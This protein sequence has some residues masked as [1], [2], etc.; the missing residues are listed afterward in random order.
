METQPAND[1]PRYVSALKLLESLFGYK[2]FRPFQYAIIDSLCDNNDVLAVMPTGGGKSI[3]YQLPALMRDGVGIVVSPLIAL[4]DD[5]VNALKLLGIRAECIHSAIDYSEINRIERALRNRQLDILYVAPERA[6]TARMLDLL[7]DTQISLFAIDEAH[8]VSQWGHDF[9]PD[10]QQLSKLKQLFPEVPTVA[11]TATADEKT[12]EEIIRQLGLIRARSYIASFDRPNIHYSVYTGANSKQALLNFIKTHYDTNTAGIVYCQTRKKV[13]STCD[14]LIQNG[15]DALPY[16]A[17]MADS[18]RQQNQKTFKDRDGLIMV[19]TIAF[20][21][22]I[23][24]PNVRFVAH[25]NIPKCLESYYQETGRAGRDGAPAYAWM[26]FNLED[27][28]TLRRLMYEADVNPIRKQINHNKLEYMLGFCEIIDCRRQ[29][30]LSYF[31]E[32]LTQPCGNCDNCHAP[33]QTRDESESARIAIS[34][35]YRSGQRF[36]VNHV[37]D[38]LLGKTTDKVRQYRHEKLSTFGLGK[39]L[40]APEWRNI[41]RQLLAHGYIISNPD[42]YGALQLA[43]K[44]R[45]LLRNE[46]SFHCRLPDKAA[47]KIKEKIDHEP[48]ILD[49]DSGLFERLKEL[50]SSIALES[51]V[52]A[53]VVLHDR[54]LKQLCADL[55]M[56]R[57]Q[58]LQI[59][60]IG[61]KKFQQYG[62]VLLSLIAEFTAGEVESA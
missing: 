7:Q 36:G 21:M 41:L 57:E 53:Y 52:P 62:E 46:E 27:V 47:P 11:L 14:W 33:P 1:T 48:E 29:S 55:P 49:Y 6:L 20:G 10:Y 60:G 3:C 43:A 19:A 58:M 31:G 59:P 44:C 56:N 15:Y 18:I 32:T 50:R 51:N 39:H 61:E 37:I 22:G 8:C 16:H 26:S 40:S 38:L 34:C 24:K 9:R 30:L 42:Q 45:P 17:G 35:I 13:E 54:T 25:T 4:M 5:Q 23:D 2:A 12:R 28:T